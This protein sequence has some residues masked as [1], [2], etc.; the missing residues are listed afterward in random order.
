M[1]SRGTVRGDGGGGGV[2]GRGRGVEAEL[3]S[4]LHISLASWCK[5]TAQLLLL[6]A[7]KSHLC[8]IYLL[9][10]VWSSVCMYYKTNWSFV[11]AIDTDG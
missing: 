7:Q 3:I 5:E 10:E 6:I 4:V 2:V 9:T 1:T 11:A 8:L